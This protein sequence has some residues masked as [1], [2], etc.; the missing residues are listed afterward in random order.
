MDTDVVGISEFDMDHKERQM[1]ITTK[2]S[3]TPT[4]IVRWKI[5]GYP[6]YRIYRELDHFI[7]DGELTSRLLYIGNMYKGEFLLFTGHTKEVW[8]K[9]NKYVKYCT[10]VEKFD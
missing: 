9:H 7:F 2:Q 8:K 5:M 6:S 3:K 4:N 10:L 1:T